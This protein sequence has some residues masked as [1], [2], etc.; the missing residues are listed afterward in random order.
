MPADGGEAK[1][2]TRTADGVGFFAWKPDGSGFAYTSLPE[3]AT[4]PKF[5][6][7]FEVRRTIT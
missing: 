2:V 1:Q 4:R 6:D 5:D 7:S 3:E